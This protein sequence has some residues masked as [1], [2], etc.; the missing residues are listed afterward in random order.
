MLSNTYKDALKFTPQPSKQL[1]LLIIVLHSC[2]GL[3]SFF[4]LN[5]PWLQQGLLVL[6]ISIAGYLSYR[7]HYKKTAKS[8]IIV[9]QLSTDNQWTI[10][11]AQYKPSQ[12]AIQAVLL[13][14]SL[15]NYSLMI[16]NFK[17]S[18][19]KTY[20]LILP[21]DAIAPALARQIRARVKVMS[22]IDASPF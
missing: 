20:S 19:G 7:L 17:I 13:D 22:S 2:A 4:L 1:R 16:L 18:T 3:I 9:V 10:H 15:L 11:L 21:R 5:A 12:A 14:S 8:S 6:I